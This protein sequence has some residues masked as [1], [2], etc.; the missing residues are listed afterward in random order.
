MVS[1]VVQGLFQ[2]VIMDSGVFNAASYHAQTVEQAVRV[3]EMVIKDL[4]CEGPDF[5][6]CLQSKND[7]EILEITGGSD[8]IET[9]WMPVPDYS[10]KADPFL[11]DHPLSLLQ[12]VGPDI[13]VMIGTTKD[14]GI[15]Y[16][17]GKLVSW[18][19]DIIWIIDFI[20]MCCWRVTGRSTETITISR[21]PGT[22]S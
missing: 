16:L 15:I 17:A 9:F 3:S 8:Y 20:E 5:L 22:S 4:N 14:E 10:Y 1:P 12:T 21:A 2:R 6:S 19:N 7:T 13:Q 11:P 18:I